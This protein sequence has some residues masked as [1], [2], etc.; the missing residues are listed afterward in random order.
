MTHAR[1]RPRS[2]R[3]REKPR[4]RDTHGNAYAGKDAPYYLKS[5]ARQTEEILVGGYWEPGWGIE[6]CE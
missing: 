2:A 3:R 6:I 1:G 5:I 4:T